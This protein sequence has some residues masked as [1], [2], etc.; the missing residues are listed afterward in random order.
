MGPQRLAADLG[1]PREQARDYIDTYFARVSRV[2]AYFD[3]Q[4]QRAR[5]LGYAETIIGRRRP[6]PELQQGKGRD[7]AFGERLAMNTP[8]QGS[9]ADLIKIA[10]VR[11]QQRLVDAGLRT[12]MLLQVHDELLF[13]A[14][15]E[16]VEAAI[17]VIR[18][19]MEH[20]WDL[21][22]PLV[23]DLHHGASWAALK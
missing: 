13:E 12:R 23:V 20:V 11:M 14:P 17:P 19:T 2:R 1:I 4:I 10:M 8:I 16:E 22:V 9:A 5:D 7:A 6:I 21:R 15:T 3:E 18:D